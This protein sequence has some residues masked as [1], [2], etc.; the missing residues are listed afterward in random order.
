MIYFLYAWVWTTTAW[1]LFQVSFRR[2]KKKVLTAGTRSFF[3][4]STALLILISAR[5]CVSST[6]MRTCRSSFRCSQFGLPRF[7]SSWNQWKKWVMWRHTS[8]LRCSRIG[9]RRSRTRIGDGARQDGFDRSDRVFFLSVCWQ[10]VKYKKC[11][12]VASVWRKAPALF[13]LSTARLEKQT[14]CPYF[15]CTET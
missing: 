3:T 10:V 14:F 9:A 8:G 5:A 2:K 15:H 4:S 11:A 1:N 6:V 7:C 12:A 13:P